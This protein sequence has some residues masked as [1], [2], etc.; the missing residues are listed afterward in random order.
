MR[1]IE[2]KQNDQNEF[3]I[4]IIDE[5]KRNEFSRDTIQ[6]LKDDGVANWDHGLRDSCASSFKNLKFL[7]FNRFAFESFENSDR[8]VDGISVFY[9]MKNCIDLRF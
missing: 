3:N 5:I 2:F 4:S 8:S 1:E 7:C 6:Y 9:R